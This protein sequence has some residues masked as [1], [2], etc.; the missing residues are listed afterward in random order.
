VRISRRRFEAGWRSFDDVTSA[1]VEAEPKGRAESVATK[2]RSAGA[3]ASAELALP[4]NMHMECIEKN[5][6]LAKVREALLLPDPKHPEDDLVVFRVFA[7]LDQDHDGKICVEEFTKRFEEAE[8]K[9]HTHAPFLYR[10]FGIMGA[11]QKLDPLAFFVSL[12]GFLVNDEDEL[13]AFCFHMF[14]KNHDDHLDLL[15]FQQMCKLAHPRMSDEEIADK[16]VAFDFKHGHD[17][18]AGGAADDLDL[19]EV[20]YK[21]HRAVF[22]DL[23][24]PVF[25]TAEKLRQE[26]GSEAYWQRRRHA[27]K[28]QKKLMEG[29]ETGDLV[30]LFH[31]ALTGGCKERLLKKRQAQ[32]DAQRLELEERELAQ[33]ALEDHAQAGRDKPAA[34]R[35]TTRARPSTRVEEGRRDVRAGGSSTTRPTS[36]P[37]T[38]TRRRATPTG[39]TTSRACR[40]GRSRRP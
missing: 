11:G 38:R 8:V 16:L 15:E 18:H 24:W 37:S 39:T 30:G 14:D 21:K 2:A 9:G 36:G 1:R 6:G 34:A 28:K 7:G 13:L 17:A 29:F 12:H 23:L 19:E 4:E 31:D 32:I 20:M 35:P 10:F 25:R 5:E 40:A 26:I 27:V 3:G 33:R 22:M